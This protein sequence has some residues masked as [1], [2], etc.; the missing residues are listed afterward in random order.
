MMFLWGLTTAQ[1]SIRTTSDLDRSR[2]TDTRSTENDKIGADTNPEYRID[3]SLVLSIIHSMIIILLVLIVFFYPHI[4]T[5]PLNDQ[6][7][8][9]TSPI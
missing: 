2:L 9:T 4:F 5:K 7:S 1:K 3:A 6:K 8:T